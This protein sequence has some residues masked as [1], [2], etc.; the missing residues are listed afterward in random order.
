MILVQVW[1]QIRLDRWYF[2][3]SRRGETATPTGADSPATAS[4]SGSKPVSTSS[5]DLQPSPAT[6]VSVTPHVQASEAADTRQRTTGDTDPLLPAAA[7]CRTTTG[8]HP[9][10]QLVTPPQ[11]LS[12]AA[13]RQDLSLAA[14][15]SDAP[16]GSGAR[17]SSVAPYVVQQPQPVARP[18]TRA[19]SRIGKPK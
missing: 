7:T 18:H 17:S 13:P 14:P 5:P 19:Q 9:A 12:P 11:D 1:E 16:K 2:M 10:N 3:L 8:E 4:A 6:Q 15:G